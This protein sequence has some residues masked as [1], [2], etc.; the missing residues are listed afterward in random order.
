MIRK[1]LN[2]GKNKISNKTE[3]IRSMKKFYCYN[4]NCPYVIEHHAY[5]SK[6]YE[7]PRDKVLIKERGFG[8]PRPIKCAYCKGRMTGIMG[9]EEMHL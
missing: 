9:V 3:I 7:Y 1:A 6:I 2:I 4:Q 5:P 8:K